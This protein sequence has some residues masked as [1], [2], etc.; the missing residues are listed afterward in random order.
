MPKVRN[1][2]TGLVWPV[3]DDHWSIGHADYELYEEP[4][5][6]ALTLDL[7]SM[8]LADLR[9]YAYENGVPLGTARTKADI[10]AAITAALAAR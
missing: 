2:R 9:A 8:T 7:E 3:H 10:R 4:E 5:P 6:L 1:L